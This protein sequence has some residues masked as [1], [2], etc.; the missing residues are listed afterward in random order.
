METSRDQTR[1]FV[2]AI[3]VH[4]LAAAVLFAGLLASAPKKP[5]I[6]GTAIEAVLVDLS[7]GRPLPRRE[8]PKPEPPKPTPK[9]QPAPPPPP[10]QAKPD[11]ITDQRPQ[12]PPAPDPEALNLERQREELRQQ[13]EELRRQQQLEQ[14][15]M[16]QL[17]DIRRQREQAARETAQRERQLADA[18]EAQRAADILN[19][20]PEPRQPEG[21][22]RPGQDVANDLLS[23][24]AGLIQEVVTQNW[25][26]PANTPAGIRCTLRVRQIPGGEVIGVSIGTPC[27]ADPL[28]QQSI[29]EAVER[30]SPLPYMGFESVFQPAL[31]FNFRYDG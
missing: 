7:V 25:R 26:R 20:Q 1:A 2:Y 28:I 31:N 24:Y 17:E 29:I 3:G 11:D 9:P 6:S 21:S 30:A 18:R 5:V 10:P 27:N 19:Q 12:L 22:Q 13:Q 23:Q 4:V 15:R 16:Q 14:Q 8:P